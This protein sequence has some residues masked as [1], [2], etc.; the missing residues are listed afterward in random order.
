MPRQLRRLQEIQELQESKKFRS[1]CGDGVAVCIAG[2][3]ISGA[4]DD[5]LLEIHPPVFECLCK[6]VLRRKSAGLGD[7]C[8]GVVGVTQQSFAVGDPQLQQV[9]NR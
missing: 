9:V 1:C 6:I 7:L 2:L 4:S 8:D 5:R 3:F